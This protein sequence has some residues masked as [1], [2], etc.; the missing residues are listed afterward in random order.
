MIANMY[1]G[2]SN[3]L[4][5]LCILVGWRAYKR[6]YPVL[7]GVSLALATIIKVSP[8]ILGVYF[9][10]KREYRVVLWSAISF[11]GL[12]L[13]SMVVLGGYAEHYAWL[14]TILP[15]LSVVKGNSILNQSFDAFYLRLAANGL[16]TE[17]VAHIL[18][19]ISSWLILLVSFGLC[20]FNRLYPD[21][22]E[23]DLEYAC[24]ASLLVLVPVVVIVQHYVFLLIAYILVL[25]YLVDR[26]S[27]S[28]L[29]YVCYGVSYTAV[30]LGA[31]GG[32][33]FTRWPFVLFQSPKLLGSLLLWGLIAFFLLKRRSHRVTPKSEV[34]E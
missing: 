27:P 29:V 12:V 26:E 11:I 19:T 33:S 15:F 30:S 24:I 25:L 2:Q 10:Y 17:S 34:I 16:F 9:L 3:V 21:S 4:I 18:H 7:C 28:P 32:Q 1:W 31:F 6:D 13:A 8:A 22:E 5:L 23:F 14:T 20:R